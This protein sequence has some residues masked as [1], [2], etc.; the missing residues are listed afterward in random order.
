M[1]KNN[2][3]DKE[4]LVERIMEV[5]IREIV[6]L[7]TLHDH[8]TEVSFTYNR[9][10]GYSWIARTKYGVNLVF[11]SQSSQEIK[12]FKTLNGAKRNFIRRL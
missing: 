3:P 4:K 8:F 11:P 9:H 12:T 6:D 5:W 7:S 1:S 2:G 10:E